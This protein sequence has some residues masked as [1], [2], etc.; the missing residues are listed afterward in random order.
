M[1]VRVE[2]IPVGGV[3]NVR[4][5]VVH[6]DASDKECNARHTVVAAKEESDAAVTRRAM[7]EAVAGQWTRHKRTT[8]CGDCSRRYG[9]AR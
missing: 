1:S 6:C 5:A 8:W 4:C 9:A 3:Y 7:V 2:H